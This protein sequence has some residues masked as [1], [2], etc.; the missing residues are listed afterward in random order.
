MKCTVAPMSEQPGVDVV[1]RT[2]AEELRVCGGLACERLIAA[3]A[4]VPR[5][6]FLPPG[7][8]IV[9][10]EGDPRGVP[11][12]DDDPRHVY[13]NVSVALDAE[14]Q[15]FNGAPGVVASWI[16]AAST[17]PGD[18]VLH[19]GCATGYYTAI[20]AACVGDDGSV[21]ALEVDEDLAARA[22]RN[23]ENHSKVSVRD[24]NLRQLPADAYDVALVSA[25]LSHPPS[26]L[27]DALAPGGRIVLPLT[28]TIPQMGTL[29]KG[30]VFR[31]E[32]LTNSRDFTVQ[33]LSFAMI[34][35]AVGV[36]DD[37]FNATLGRALM[38]GTAP[39]RLR[40]DPHDASP[41][42]WLHG[43]GFCLA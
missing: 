10:G 6:R 13:R 23:L 34:Y 8:W 28:A 1:R 22:R 9:R 24:G 19:V 41:E 38:R 21:T 3:F 17:R 4:T 31:L 5:E 2:F 36:R 12:P 30:L 43:E 16:D 33:R 15:L 20:L 39:A 29:G 14:R 25:G 26:E 42:C 18:R 11:T 40:R 32:R 37:R 7:P 35:S 27:L